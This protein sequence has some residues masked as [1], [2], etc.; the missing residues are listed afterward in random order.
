M[1]AAI[2]INIADADPN[3]TYVGI[4]GQFSIDHSHWGVTQNFSES[5][6]GGSSFEPDYIQGGNAG[7]LNVFGAQAVV[8]DG[9]MTAEAFP[10]L[11]QTEAG[12][13][14]SGTPQGGNFLPEG[15]SFDLGADSGLTFPA[16]TDSFSGEPGS[17]II[18][19]YAPS[20]D[21]LAPNFSADTPLDTAALNALGAND[22]NNIL[23][24]TTAPAVPLSNGGFENVT[25][26]MN[27]GIRRLR[28]RH[29][30]AK[31]GAHGAA[32]RFYHDQRS[33]H[34]QCT[35]RSDCAVRQDFDL[36][37]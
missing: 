9:A 33:Q 4:A 6:L 21:N 12:L 35:G 5:L 13:A 25:V 19:N 37:W 8:L 22:P 34:G 29:R 16:N 30:C 15:G 17:V 18:Q 10:G 31:H 28:P 3:D 36:D 11:K 32:R 20:L 7:T 1:R 2:S 27:S 14:P 23:D 24:W 26:T